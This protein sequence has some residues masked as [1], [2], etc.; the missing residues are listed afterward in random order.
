MVSASASRPTRAS[1]MSAT[2]ACF[3]ASNAAMLRLTNRRSG[4]WKAVREAV[5]KSL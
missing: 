1:A 3:P 2:P 4:F 5:V